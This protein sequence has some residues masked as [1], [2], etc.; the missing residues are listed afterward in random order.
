MKLKILLLA[1]ILLVVGST[2]TVLMVQPSTH[3]Q[4][5]PSQWP[6]A[7]S[8]YN[9]TFKLN[10]RPPLWPASQ[11]NGGTNGLPAK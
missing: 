7:I 3:R 9:Q 11:I 8:N 4:A 2:I 6:T 1:V 10:T 5:Q